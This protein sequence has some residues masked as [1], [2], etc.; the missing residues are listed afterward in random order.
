[1]ATME[2]NLKQ[3]ASGISANVSAQILQGLQGA[4]V[5]I[6]TDKVALL[7]NP[8][9]TNIVKNYAVD[10]LGSVP[11][12]LF[13]PVWISSL[14]GAIMLYLAGNKRTFNNRKELYIFQSIQSAV[15]I[16]YGFFAG[17]LVTWYSTWVLGYEFE[18]Y[19]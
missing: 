6:S 13:V 2:T 17:Y 1:A 4:G 19:N 16:V 10:K 12:A 14:L 5:P 9:A 7:A 15:P 18:S 11:S 3:I 8:V